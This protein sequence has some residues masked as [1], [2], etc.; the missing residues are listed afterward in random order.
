MNIPVE[1]GDIFSNFAS[2]AKGIYWSHGANSPISDSFG[3]HCGFSY[4]CLLWAYYLQNVGN[5]FRSNSRIKLISNLIERQ[6]SSYG[7]NY[8]SLAFTYSTPSRVTGTRLYRQQCQEHEK[9]KLWK[10]SKID[11]KYRA[12]EQQP[13]LMR[14]FLASSRRREFSR[15]SIAFTCYSSWER[16]SFLLDI[17]STFSPSCHILT[18][19]KVGGVGGLC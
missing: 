4:Y 18:G 3:I 12:S 6:F 9:G 15:F 10:E 19:V 1:T 16:I 2:K 5:S 11:L 7:T 13:L 17:F 8:K 14:D